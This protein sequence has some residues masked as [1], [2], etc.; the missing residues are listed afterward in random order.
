MFWFAKIIGI[1]IIF[2]LTL[3]S[4]TVQTYTPH[5]RGGENSLKIYFYSFQSCQRE[6]G[7]LHL[8]LWGID[9]GFLTSSSSLSNSLNPIN[10]KLYKTA[11]RQCHIMIE[12]QYSQKYKVLRMRCKHSIKVSQCRKCGLHCDQTKN[13]KIPPNLLQGRDSLSKI[14]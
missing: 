4:D 11:V 9:K 12:K 6:H 7:F 8:I 14:L 1:K 2:Y 10:N 5:L 13:I 3:Q